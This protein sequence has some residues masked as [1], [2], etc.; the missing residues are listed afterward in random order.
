MLIALPNTDGSFTGTLFLPFTGEPSFESIQ[1][2]TALERFFKSYFP[3]ALALA[4]AIEEEYFSAEASFLATVH[5]SSWIYNDSA[6]LIGDAAHAIV[7]FYGQGMN[8]GFEDV[9]ILNELL[10]KHQDNWSDTLKEYQENRK[11]NTDAI[12]ELAMQNFI[13]MRDL[14]ADETFVLRKK[15]EAA[16]HK[17]YKNYLPLYSM[18]T[19][20]DIPYSEALAKGKEYDWLMG[21]ILALE[22]KTP[23]WTKE[24]AWEA[25]EEILLKYKVI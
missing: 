10:D 21:E 8:A 6:F 17:R 12:A 16:I 22:Y 9:R 7:P 11:P 13:E 25:V 3:D 15:I 23:Y 18:V 1:D 4:G 14:V 19:F 24:K 5:T 20:S 2:K